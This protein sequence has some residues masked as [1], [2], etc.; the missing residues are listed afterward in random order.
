[1]S[2][3]TLFRSRTTLTVGGVP[4][5]LTHYWDDHA[6]VGGTALATEALARVRAMLNSAAGYVAIGTTVSFDTQ[7]VQLDQTTGQPIGA[8]TGS[9]PGSITFSG[10]GD[11]LPLATQ[12]L[13]RFSTGVYVGGRALTG[14]MFIPGATEAYST[15]GAGPTAA[16]VSAWNTALGLLGTT[17]TS[18]I[19]Q[20]VWHRPGAKSGTP[21]SAEPVTGRSMATTWAVQKGRRP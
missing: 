6:I 17:I 9:A 18:D 21:G 1:M 2:A 11:P 12:A 19:N 5:M 13:A 4:C 14:R 15:G 3:G 16:Y 7:V 8:F 10:S 20:V